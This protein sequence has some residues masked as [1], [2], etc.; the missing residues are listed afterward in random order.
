M[1]GLV[2]IVNRDQEIEIGDVLQRV[3]RHADP[4]HV[5]VVDD[6]SVDHSPAIAESLGFRVVRHARNLGI[7][8]AIRT[9]IRHAQALR[10]HFVTVFAANGK[11]QPEEISRVE[12][13]IRSGEY[14]YVQG[15]R[16]LASGS[17]PGLT[18][19]RRI[20]IPIFSRGANL[21]LGT[22]FSDITCGFRSYRLELFDRT[23][24][25]IDQEWLNR[26]EMEYYIQFWACRLGL[27]VKEVPVSMVYSHLKAGRESKIVPVL[28]W[29][30][31]LRPFLYLP[32]GLR[33]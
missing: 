17:S 4:E 32:T 10:Y 14:D 7:G 9:G 33:R 2:V 3:K 15:S 8:A 5:V 25:D 20:A 30:S 24:L 28:D 21:A 11:M 18:R 12:A 22:H 23:E 13:P 1:R 26:Y 19:F 6:G 27:R 31:M 16:Y 29:W